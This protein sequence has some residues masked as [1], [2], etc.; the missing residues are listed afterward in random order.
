V[1]ILLVRHGQTDE[2]AKGVLQGQQDTQLNNLGR[3]Q[4][5]AIAARLATFAPPVTALV[6]SN[7][8]RAFD[9]ARSAARDL[10]LEIRVD[11]RWGERGFG[12]FEGKTLGEADIW[13]AAAG[14][15]DLPGAE[16]MSAFR[17]R[18]VDAL[19]EVV[20]AH[21]PEA[22]VAVVTHGGTMR[23][24]LALFADGSLPLEDGEPTPEVV[25]IANCS[26][27]HLIAVTTVTALPR[28]RI[29]CVNDVAHLG[30]LADRVPAAQE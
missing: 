25:P 3:M 15:S 16:P 19:A 29:V 18:V 20:R 30:A 10:G 27:M 13:R 12:T 17:E 26:L 14:S 9:T 23:A 4:A 2:N 1:H 7:L 5:D 8:S 24:T 11:A 6:S 22:C 28:W 21:H